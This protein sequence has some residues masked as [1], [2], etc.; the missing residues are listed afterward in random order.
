M[1]HKGS[2]DGTKILD[3]VYRYQNGVVDDQCYPLTYCF[4]G[5][6]LFW[7]NEQKKCCIV[8]IEENL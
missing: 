3:W 2:T 5:D 7:C 6:D 1:Y 4:I 8:D